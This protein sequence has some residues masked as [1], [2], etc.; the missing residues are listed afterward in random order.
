VRTSL[1][2]GLLKTVTSNRKMPLPI[3][4]FEI[5]EVVVK[6]ASRETGARNERRLAAVNYNKTPGFEVSQCASAADEYNSLLGQRVLIF[7]RMN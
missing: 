4:L 2:P 7:G 1:I 3:K 6:D 5:Q